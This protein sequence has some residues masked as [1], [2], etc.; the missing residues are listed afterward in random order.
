MV[1]VSVTAMTKI[2]QDENGFYHMSFIEGGHVIFGVD[3]GVPPGFAK[4]A[5]METRTTTL[6]PM[7]DAFT[8]PGAFFALSPYDLQRL[9]DM[10]EDGLLAPETEH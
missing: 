6:V 7:L 8:T 2:D 3:D 4:L 9:L 10:V 5:N 1:G